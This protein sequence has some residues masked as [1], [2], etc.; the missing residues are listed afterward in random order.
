VKLWN[1]I[2]DIDLQST[3]TQIL[4]KLGEFNYENVLDDIS[5]ITKLSLEFRENYYSEMES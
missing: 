2:K 3:R 1:K 5:A 4:R